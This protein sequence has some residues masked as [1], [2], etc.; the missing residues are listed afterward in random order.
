SSGSLECDNR[1][2]GFLS[3]LLLAECRTHGS[4][5]A[6]NRIEPASRFS[7]EAVRKHEGGDKS[8]A[9]GQ[10]GQ[11]NETARQVAAQYRRDTMSPIMVS[12]VLRLVE[13]AFLVL[14]GAI[15]FAYYVGLG[16]YLDWYY[17]AVIACAS[18]LAVIFLDIADCYQLP[19]LI[20]P[21]PQVTRITIVWAGT[22]ALFAVVG[23][24]LKLA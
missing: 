16:T 18:L 6:M 22:L 15:L 17:P 11:L 10:A 23:F 12:G 9:S 1:I 5:A 4:A 21:V 20:R 8:Q 7:V 3:Y 2:Q 13:L 14:S 24:F 19:A